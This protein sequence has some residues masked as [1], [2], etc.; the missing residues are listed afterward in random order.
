MRNLTIGAMGALFFIG[1]AG[2]IG[3]IIAA[4]AGF[5]LAGIAA[6]LLGAAAMTGA[7]M[8]ADAIHY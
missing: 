7:T 1:A 5:T 2:T 6:V 4:P 8:L 3:G